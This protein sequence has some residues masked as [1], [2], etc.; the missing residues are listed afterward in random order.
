MR[1]IS[2]FRLEI[3]NGWIFGFQQQTLVRGN[4]GQKLRGV[5]IEMDSWTD[6][7]SLLDSQYKGDFGLNVDS[8]A[9]DD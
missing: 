8:K 5:R 3:N 2:N 6:K 9:S 1:V 4:V 7:P